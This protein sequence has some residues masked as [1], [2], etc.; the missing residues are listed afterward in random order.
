MGHSGDIQHD[1]ENLSLK[2]RRE[3]VLI[4]AMVGKVV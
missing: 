1:L 2:F 4:S 3:E